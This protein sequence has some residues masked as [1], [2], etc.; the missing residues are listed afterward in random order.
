MSLYAVAYTD[1]MDYKLTLEMIEASGPEAAMIKKLTAL[2]WDV[3]NED[4]SSSEKI[5]SFV[6]VCD[7]GITAIGITGPSHG[8]PTLL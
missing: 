8:C 1:F 2:G 4:L 7:S 3:E 6:L 5:K